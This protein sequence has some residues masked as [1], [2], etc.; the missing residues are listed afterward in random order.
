MYRLTPDVE[1]GS[2]RETTPTKVARVERFLDNA[3]GWARRFEARVLE[4]GIVSYDDVGAGKSYLTRE[5]IAASMDS[6]VGRPIILVV[7]KRR[8]GTPY[9]GHKKITPGN[10]EDEAC[11][12]ISDWYQDPDGWFCV[13]GV[14]FDDDAIEA[15]NDVGLC[16]CGYKVTRVGAGGEYHAIKY[17]NE[18]KAFS[19]EH[20]AIVDRPRYEGATIRLNSKQPNQKSA[21]K[22]LFWKKT[23]AASAA[24]PAGGATPPAPAAAAP[25][26]EINNAV[27]DITGESELEIPGVNAGDPGRKVTLAELVTV[28]NAQGDL[29]GDDEVDVGNGKKVKLNALVA[30]HNKMCALED[31]EKKKDKTNAVAPVVASPAAPAAAPAAGER[32]ENAK[33]GHFRVLLNASTRPGAAIAEA[34]LA[35]SPDSVEDRLARGRKL[36]GSKL[37][38]QPGAN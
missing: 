5:S 28:F 25:G 17:D 19:G 11:G 27:T 34:A 9:L 14:V 1:A 32:K 18:I 33:P 36:Y 16:S 35:G 23:P 13:R 21:M 22:L 37:P 15:I 12:Y 10:L 38:A 31:E 6:F 8:N 4:P 2:H 7:K 26:A 3:K 20:L 29:D 30:S 24:A